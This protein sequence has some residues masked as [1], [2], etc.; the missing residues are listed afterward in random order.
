MIDFESEWK[1]ASATLVS[2]LNQR[3]VSK[4]QWQELFVTVHRI[5]TWVED[6]SNLV[7]EEFQ[8]EVHRYVLGASNRIGIHEEDNAILRAYVVEWGKFCAQAEYIP[9]PFCYI[10]EHFHTATKP[11]PSMQ[12]TVDLVS[13]KMLNDWNETIF[14]GMKAKLQNAA[15]RLIEAERNGEDFDPQ[16]VI[17]VRQSYVSLSLINHDNL[18]AYKDNFERAYIDETEQ[19][20]MS[21]A[22]QLAERCVAILVVQ[23]QEQILSECPALISERQTE[24]LRMLYRLINKT[25]DGIDPILKY[26]DEFIKAEGLNDML[27]NAETITTD[28]E[29]YVEQLLTMFSKFSQLVLNAFYDD[30]RCLTARD[31]AFQSVVNDTS[32][33]KLEIANSKIRGAGRV[34]AESRCPELL[35]NYTDL[36]LRKTGLSKRLTSE[37]IDTKLNDVVRFSSF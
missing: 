11:A 37:E 18:A 21:H 32:V 25:P 16:L 19:F 4:R 24:K 28:P 30:P 36:L 12:D 14:T 22:P 27:A 5:C 7:E 34:Q 3:S 31:K 20:Y 26:L 8:K 9:K 2:L 23:F 15:L 6:G 1:E 35:A 33:F 13:L 17:G 10:L 29:K